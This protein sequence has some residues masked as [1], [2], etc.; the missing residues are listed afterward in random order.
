M[1]ARPGRAMNVA[2]SPR[3]W[4]TC[5]TADRNSTAASA[6]ASALIGANEIS[7]C[8]GPHSSSMALGGRPSAHRASRMAS[9]AGAIESSRFSD[10]NW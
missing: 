6:A 3:R 2:S 7:T 1:F 8:P 10:R 4:Q 9:S 5:L